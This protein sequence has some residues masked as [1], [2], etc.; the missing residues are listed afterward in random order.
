MSV[1]RGLRNLWRVHKLSFVLLGLAVLAVLGSIVAYKESPQF[2]TDEQIIGPDG[3]LNPCV[4]SQLL[5]EAWGFGL[6]LLAGTLVLA[7]LIVGAI[8][9]MR[10]RHTSDLVGMT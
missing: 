1:R 5:H 3:P 9:T 2:C 7:S 10:R 6:G 4:D 8:S